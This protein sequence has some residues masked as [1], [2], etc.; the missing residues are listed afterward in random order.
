M[1]VPLMFVEVIATRFA[2]VVMP[3]VAAGDNDALIDPALIVP[4]TVKSFNV[5]SEVILGCD[6]VTIFPLM[7]VDVIATRFANVV[8]PAV[9]AG[10]NGA[11]IAP[12]L[13]VPET[14]KLSKVPTEVIFGCDAVIILPLILVEVMAERLPNAV[15]PDKV[16]GDSEPFTVPILATPVTVMDPKLFNPVMPATVPGESVP[17]NVPPIIVPVT[18]KLFNVP[19]EV[20]LGCAAVTIVP[21]MLVDVIATRF[22]KLV[23]PAVTAGDNGALIDPALI[24]PATV[25][26]ARVPTEVILG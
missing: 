1:L 20:I 4:E 21:L 3:A 16:P 5:P 2:S 14:V 10:D 12:A 9:A 25:K 24:V 8:M 18:V 7:L 15:I 17:L 26:L 11:L 22:A 6:A 13:I 23:M 19:M